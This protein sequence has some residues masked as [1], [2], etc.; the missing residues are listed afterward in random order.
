M[1]RIVAHG[2]Y[3][4]PAWRPNHRHKEREWDESKSQRPTTHDP[5]RLERAPTHT[6]LKLISTPPLA[7]SQC[8]TAVVSMIPPPHI[9]RSTQTKHQ[10]WSWFFTKSKPKPKIPNLNPNPKTLGD[11]GLVTQKERSRLG[12][13]SLVIR[14]EREKLNNGER[15]RERGWES[16]NSCVVL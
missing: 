15:E 1:A 10:L 7:L 8:L 6:N 11:S 13:S 4:L 14:R 9:P 12:D 16:K 5:R 2:L 3:L